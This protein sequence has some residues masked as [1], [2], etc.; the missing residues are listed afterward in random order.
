[1][2]GDKKNLEINS[3]M[4]KTS[5]N[6]YLPSPWMNSNDDEFI[7][8]TGDTNDDVQ[9]ATTLLKQVISQKVHRHHL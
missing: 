1:M 7:H 8:I 5:T 2:I 3:I 4:E 6:I 9:R